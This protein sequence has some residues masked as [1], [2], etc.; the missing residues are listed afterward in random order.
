MRTG[1]ALA[2]PKIKEEQVIEKPEILSD[3]AI[4]EASQVDMFL[5]NGELDPDCGYLRGRQQVA[6]AQC[7]DT[8]KKDLKQ[9]IEWG[10]EPCPHILTQ[11]MDGAETKRRNCDACWQALQ[12][13][14]EV[15]D[16]LPKTN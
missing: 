12:S 5:P 15:K 14:L 4:L 16:A 10:N 6:Q 13:Q 2:Q 11:V 1:K 9:F 3:E 7:D 8:H